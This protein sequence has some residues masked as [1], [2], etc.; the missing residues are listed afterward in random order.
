MT[1]W[2]REACILWQRATN[3]GLI[4]PGR[5]GKALKPLVDREGWDVVQLGF[6]HYLQVTELRFLSPE[7]FVATYGEWAMKPKLRAA[8][9]MKFVVDWPEGQTRGHFLQVPIDDPR[10][11][12]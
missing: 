5:M 2:V 6:R 10:P 3:G 8:P 9:Q 7:R 4:A 11:A 12:A 1:H